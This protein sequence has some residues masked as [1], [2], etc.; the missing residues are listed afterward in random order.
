M[1]KL[2]VRKVS[3]GEISKHWGTL[4]VIVPP[5][6]SSLLSGLYIRCNRHG[7]INWNVAPIYFEEELIERNNVVI[8]K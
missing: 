3:R 6:G 7:I 1:K 8:I 4:A 5:R 2:H